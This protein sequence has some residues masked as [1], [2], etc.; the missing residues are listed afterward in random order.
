M[1]ISIQALETR[2]GMEE[3][4]K[5]IEIKLKENIKWRDECFVIECKKILFPHS[6]QNH[7]SF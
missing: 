2:D 3:E 7:L 5:D 4:L 6:V 1:K